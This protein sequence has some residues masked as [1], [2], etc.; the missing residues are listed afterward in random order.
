M[1]TIVIT[2]T[3]VKTSRFGLGTASL[4]HLF[5]SQDRQNL[6]DTAWD[7]GFTHFDTA[8]MYGE[9]VA[10]RELGKFLH[11]KR[12]NATIATKF[13]LPPIKLLQK[14]PALIYPHKALGKF[15]RQLLPNW[16]DKRQRLLTPAAAEA[17]LSNSLQALG[18]DWLD[19]LFLHEPLASEIEAIQAL[20][21]WLQRQKTSGR[22]RYLGLAG[23]AQDCL[24]IK[25]Q[26]EGL[27]DILQV[28]DSLDRKEADLIT[29][30]GRPL[31]ITFG[32][33]RRASAHSS[34]LTGDT[35]L[36]QALA[37]NKDGM[38]LV[39]SRQPDRLRHL[40]SLVS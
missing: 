16:W 39:S 3:S 9:G 12:Q 31:Q 19:I 18:T 29:Q 22:V 10:E 33:L 6:L 23:N 35:I 5:Y 11:K 17:S 21:N 28:E 40:A 7:E 36:N 1:Q 13:G 24:K 25:E 20:A 26:T 15:G 38:I 8:P 37:R 14:F 4:H 2:H 27:F 30:S 34:Q 32:Y